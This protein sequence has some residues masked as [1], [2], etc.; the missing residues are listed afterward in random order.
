LTAPDVV[1]CRQKSTCSEAE[2]RPETLAGFL[3]MGITTISVA[4]PLIP[5]VK[6]AVRGLAL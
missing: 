3:R 2:G 1:K 6:D 4:P 5:L